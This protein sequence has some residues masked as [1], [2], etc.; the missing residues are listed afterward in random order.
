MRC[1][2]CG[3]EIKEGKYCAKHDKKQS[4][5]VEDKEKRK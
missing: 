3:K 1:L 5:L 2:I 4:R